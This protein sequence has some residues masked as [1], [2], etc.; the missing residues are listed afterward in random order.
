MRSPQEEGN[1]GEGVEAVVGGGLEHPALSAVNVAALQA[2]SS[3]EHPGM[4]TANLHM[5]MSSPPDTSSVPTATGALMS[6]GGTGSMA[7]MLG[8]T[9]TNAN[10]DWVNVFAKFGVDY[11]G[12]D[13]AGG[14]GDTGGFG[15]AGAGSGTGFEYGDDGVGGTSRATG[16]Y[17]TN[18]NDV[19]PSYF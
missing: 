6:F 15:S 18:E 9:E 8:G 5:A 3:M 16:G 17:D 4:S 13:T 7:D 14:Y 12:N 19:E 10:P 2:S 1:E 11:D